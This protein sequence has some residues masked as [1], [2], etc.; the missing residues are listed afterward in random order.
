MSTFPINV[1]NG[2]HVPVDVTIERR[3]E[4]GTFFSTWSV[5]PIWGGVDRADVGGWAVGTEAL[6]LRL[7]AACLA[8]VVHY[9]TR[10]AEDVNGNTYVANT[11]RVMAKYA[12]ADLKA[13]GF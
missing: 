6:A 4:P 10:I 9:D 12:N 3:P 11:R 2:Q 8:G 13:L 5:S 1:V 7:K